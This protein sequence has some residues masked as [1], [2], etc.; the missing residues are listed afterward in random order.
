MKDCFLTEID[1][2]NEDFITKVIT[3][4]SNFINK[5]YSA[6]PWNRQS[7]F[8]NF[9]KPQ[10]NMSISLKDH[11]F[12]RIFACCEGLV[13]HNDDIAHYLDRFRNIVNGISILDRIFVEM[14]ILKP[15]FCSVAHVGI[16]ITKLFQALLID[17]DKNYSTLAVAFP[18][19]YEEL[20]MVD[21]A[22]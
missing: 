19:L 17:P 4:L 11:L 1:F 5:D 3:C 20:K 2:A 21:T 9:I 6:K 7:H 15:I 14:P 16:H 12:S 10:K 8:D 22:D 13:Y 18:K